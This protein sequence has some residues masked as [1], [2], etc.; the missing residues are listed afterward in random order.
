M[1]P[2]RLYWWNAVPNF[3]DAIS[4]VIV[5]HLAGREVRH[6]APKDAEIFAIGSL[7][8][9]VRRVFTE[10]TPPDT[11]PVIWGSGALRAIRGNRLMGKV[12]FALVRGPVTA[13]LLGIETDSFGDPGLLIS[14]VWPAGGQQREA[15]G[16]V[17][18]HSL[19]DDPDTQAF[20]RAHPELSLIDPRDPADQVCE[21][22]AGCRHVFA[23][24]LHGLVVAD[25][26][27]VSN[28]WVD[29]RG[30][31]RLK[32]HDYAASLGRDMRA[33]LP[34]GAVTDHT[35]PDPE[36]PLPYQ[37]AIDAARAALRRSFPMQLRQEH[38]A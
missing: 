31:G 1:T 10:G 36:A 4:P 18:H 7:L 9:V 6:A 23:S 21:A 35:L 28:T 29:P 8:N 34:P 2:L 38:A 22:I 20:V 11:H 30:Q 12:Q 17:P 26:Y 25:A 15:L 3:G 33:P 5:G 24:S 13:S 32:Y 14:D 19:M 37:P 16:F 27:G